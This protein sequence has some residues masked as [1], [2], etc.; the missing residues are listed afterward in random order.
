MDSHQPPTVS[1]HRIRVVASNDPQ[2]VGR[3]FPLEAPSVL[4]GRS[5]ECGVAL[6]DV[7]VSRRHAEIL[8]AQGEDGLILVDKGSANGVWVGDQR[9]SRHRLQLGERFRVGGTTLE[10]CPGVETLG[11]AT[12]HLPGLEL[13]VPEAPSTPSPH[14]SAAAEETPGVPS[15][16]PQAG[17]ATEHLSALR[18]GLPEDDAAPPPK[19]AGVGSEPSPGA[20]DREPASPATEHLSKLRLDL[21]AAPAKPEIEGR[22]EG[23]EDESSPSQSPVRG[24]VTQHLSGLR[25]GLAG[26][27]QDATPE[28]PTGAAGADAAAQ[29]AP[30][31]AAPE[32]DAPE[33]EA[34]EA[35]APKPRRTDLF[36]QLAL[37]RSPLLAL[38]QSEEAGGNRPF[39]LD[40][41]SVVWVVESGKVEIFTVSVQH[42]APVGARHHYLTVEPGQGFFGMD[43]HRYALPSGFLAVGSVGTVLRRI[44]VAYLRRLA[45]QGKLKEDIAALVDRWVSGLAQS[46]TAEIT[47]GPVVDV[48]LVEG[49]EVELERTQ[50][51]RSVKGTL[52]LEVQPGELLWVD[53]EPLRFEER[54]LFPVTSDTWLEASDPFGSHVRLVARSS[55]DLLDEPAYW[56]GLERFHEALCRTEFLNKRLAAVDELNR[57]RSKAENAEMARATAMRHLASVLTPD[58]AEMPA[59]VDSGEGDLVLATMQQVGQALGVEIRG[60]PDLAEVE[61]YPSKVAL[62]AKS[63]GVRTRVVALRGDWW[64]DEHGPLLGRIEATGRPVALIPRGAKAYDCLD[65]EAGTR[66]AVSDQVAAELTPFAYSIYRPF[67]Q[68]EVSVGKLI[69]FGTRGLSR[70][71]LTLVIMGIGL[72]LLGAVVPYFTGHVFDSAIPHAERDLLVQIALGLAVAA[73]ASSAYTLTQSIAMLRIQGKMDYSIQA[74]VWDRLLDLP[75]TFFKKYTSGDLA[76]RASGISAIRSLIAGSGV[77]AILGSLSSVFYVGLMFVYSAQLALLAIALTL[78]FITFTTVANYLQLR[79]QRTEMAIR[80]R[81]SGLV[82]QLISGVSK[83]RVAGAENHAF[84][85]WAEKFTEQRSIAFRIGRIQNT[86]AVFNSAFPILSSMAIFLVLASIQQRA[87]EA[88][89]GG[90]LTTGQFIAFS[91][92]YGLFVA[93]MQS[94]SDASLSMLQI[95]PIYERLRPVLTSPAEVD[96]TKS[97]P[98]RLKGGIELSHIH[99]R[100]GEDGPWIIKDVSLTIEPGEFIAFVGA[101][102]SGKST[103]MRLML[104]FET[105]AKGSVYYDGQDLGNLDLR[106][107]RQQMGVVLQESRLLPADIF[108]NIVGATART[109]DEAWDAAR[110]AGLDEDL[111][112]MPMGMHT[113]VSEGGGGLSGGQR[114]R[115][116]IARA[117]VNKPR[118]IFMD[119]ATSALDNR[120]QAVV[121]ESLRRLQAT[122]VVIAHRLSTIVDADRI[123]YLEGGVIR[124]MGTYQELMAKDGLFAQLAKRQIA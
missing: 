80:G 123:C 53:M 83:L 74:A 56:H 48:S 39:L 55:A 77:G 49:Q 62:V 54:G 120:T 70:D 57:L 26:A 4:I 67:D 34:P 19:E 117:I 20:S 69:R 108:T 25:V 107:V 6:T 88:G 96:R 14:G 9:V 93:A 99:F 22:Q 1:R 103:I 3:E 42:G 73:L 33:V 101:S 112:E 15:R 17:P 97:Y 21:P 68:G 104:G 41:P 118:I 110:A 8:P 37:P 27:G 121:T 105:P 82:L 113:Y 18:P 109:L 94:L 98:G 87:A 40:D 119:E 114:Q 50:R 124:E 13:E 79:H 65:L 106:E 75:S 45:A 23:G 44:P 16:P 60:H 86:V 90:V 95:V 38:G 59:V 115:L 35:E 76:D 36:V 78:L 63:S 2:L 66:H 71:L 52:W 12:Q 7:Q 28:V 116:L 61:T 85:V 122:R 100:Y 64:K 11:P 30:V 31:P 58:T 24:P 51:A 10:V 32:A 46:L 89:G 111:K 47:P 84:R 91:A 102:G 92:A 81:I 72:G 29:P 5:E 43:L